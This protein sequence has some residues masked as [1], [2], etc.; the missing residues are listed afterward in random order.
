MPGF[1]L[2]FSFILLLQAQWRKMNIPLTNSAQT[3]A[4]LK[5]AGSSLCPPF[6]QRQTH[7]IKG[8]AK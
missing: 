4:L 5:V 7:C 8:T 2:Q 3:D 1:V 6:I